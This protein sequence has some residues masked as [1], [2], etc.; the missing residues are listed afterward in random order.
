VASVEVSS[1]E[2]ERENHDCVDSCSTDN[3]Q[4][5]KH[6]KE[7]E[8]NQKTMVI[9]MKKRMMILDKLEGCL[10]YM[11]AICQLSLGFV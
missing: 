9:L 3:C 5:K 6:T 4:K 2:R 7:W 11:H 10:K 1:K 8:R